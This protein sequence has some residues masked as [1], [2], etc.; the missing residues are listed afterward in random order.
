MTDRILWDCNESYAR[1]A[2]PI[3]EM[4]QSI[5]IKIKINY[6]NIKHLPA[7]I[8][9]SDK[10]DVTWGVGKYFGY[11]KKVGNVCSKPTY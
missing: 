9:P 6:F 3:K 4:N 8:V 5:V 1:R 2:T 7:C 11:T 10:I